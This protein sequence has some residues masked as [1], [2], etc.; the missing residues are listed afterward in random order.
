MKEW[1]FTKNAGKIIEARELSDLH[2][3]GGGSDSS[4]RVREV[5]S[6]TT[7]FNKC[8]VKWENGKESFIELGGTYSKDDNIAVIYTND[9]LVG[10]MN[11]TTDE[12]QTHEKSMLSKKEQIIILTFIVVSVFLS[13]AIIGIPFLIV[14]IIY[15]VMKIKTFRTQIKAYMASIRQK[16]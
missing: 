15:I 5:R 8:R 7:H 9:R 16:A 14:C 6:T 11:L 13:F 1:K 10:E 4:G 2:I 3:S 12:Y